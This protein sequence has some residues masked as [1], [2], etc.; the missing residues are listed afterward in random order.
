[1]KTLL[2]ERLARL[3]GVVVEEIKSV[4]FEVPPTSS[5]YAIGTW[6]LLADGTKFSCQF[7]RLIKSGKPVIS[8]FDHGQKYGHPEPIDAINILRE[9]LRHK[10]VLGVIM[11][12]ETGD[13]RFTISGEFILEAF[14][15][16]GYEIW[17]LTF[18]DGT[19]EYSNY[20]L[21]P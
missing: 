12:G 13:L 11:S 16:T 19:G 21:A 6:I 10:T 7:W 15:F 4:E 5:I 20:A 8:I 2:K 18:S 9:S 1:M 14:N 17:E 3:S